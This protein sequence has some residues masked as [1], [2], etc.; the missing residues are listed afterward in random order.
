MNGFSDVVNTALTNAPPDPTDKEETLHVNLFQGKGVRALAVAD[1]MDVWLSA[2]LAEFM[3]PLGI[4]GQETDDE[5]GI[6]P[7]QRSHSVLIAN[8]GPQR[9]FV[10]NMS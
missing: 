10:I 5:Y 4:L 3:L 2:H 1:D 7:V 8:L 9:T 6:S